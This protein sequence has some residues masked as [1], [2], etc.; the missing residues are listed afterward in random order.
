MER[1]LYSNM[2]AQKCQLATIRQMQDEVRRVCVCVRVYVGVCAC[3]HA[4]WLYT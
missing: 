3:V 1:I 4:G 2:T